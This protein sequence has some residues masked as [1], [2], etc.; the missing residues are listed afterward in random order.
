MGDAPCPRH[1]VRA[2][3]YMVANADQPITLEDLARIAGVSQRTLFNGFK[4]FKG[5]APMS[6]LRSIRM[7][8]VRR[9]LL[10]AA[11]GANVAEI[12]QKFGFLH[13]G[14]FAKAYHEIYDERPSDTLRKNCSSRTR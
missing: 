4:Q 6:C 10:E 5:V 8:R 12:A 13:L 9:E 2:Y 1:V 14:R 11:P 7:Q 3:D